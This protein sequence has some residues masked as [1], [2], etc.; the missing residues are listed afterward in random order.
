MTTDTHSLQDSPFGTF[1]LPSWRQQVLNLGRMAPAGK[2]GL[3]FVSL[4]R[5]LALVGVDSGGPFDVPLGSH[6]NARLYPK[7][8]RCEKRVLCGAQLWDLPERIAL[9]EALETSTRQPFVFF[10]V[11]AN[12]G[13][14]SLFVSQKARELGKTARC[15]AIEPSPGI[16]ARLQFNSDASDAGLEIEKVAVSDQFGTGNLGGGGTNLGSTSLWREDADGG[17]EVALEPLLAIV[18]RTGVP[19]IDAMKVDVEGEDEKVLKAYFRDADKSL[20][21]QMLIVETGD[22]FNNPIVDLAKAHGYKPFRSTK[23][24]AVL[25]LPDQT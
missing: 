8:N 18:E 6:L 14:Y 15:V 10:D 16:R 24:N 12:V 21:P 19:H 22:H 9:D 11:G 1:R 23:M 13:L 25:T 3:W 7:D 2:P 20:Y 5:K 4:L 17:E